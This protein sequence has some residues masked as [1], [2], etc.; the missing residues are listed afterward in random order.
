MISKARLSVMKAI[1][2]HLHIDVQH[3]EYQ[4]LQNA[5]LSSLSVQTQ[6]S[7][8]TFTAKQFGAHK[9]RRLTW[10][11]IRK[12]GGQKSNSESPVQ[13]LLQHQPLLRNKTQQGDL[14]SGKVSFQTAVVISNSQSKA[15]VF[16]HSSRCL[17]TLVLIATW[18]QL[19][20]H[21]DCIFKYLF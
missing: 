7:Y 6:E 18:K 11:S 19:S 15:K 8:T 21:T 12:R 16:F 5:P 4:G 3:E 14:T 13:N 2:F 10:V 9:P 17:T 20:D 1:H